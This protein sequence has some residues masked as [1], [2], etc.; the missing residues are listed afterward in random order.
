M[1]S[2]GLGP[3]PRA[4]TASPQRHL[5]ALT[6][7]AVPFSAIVLSD[8]SWETTLKVLNCGFGFDF[9]F[10]V[11]MAS[12]SYMDSTQWIQ[13][14]LDLQN[15]SHLT[16]PSLQAPESHNSLLGSLYW[17]L[18][19]L[20]VFVCCLWKS[21][22]NAPFLKLLSSGQ[23]FL[24]ESEAFVWV[25]VFAPEQQGHGFTTVLLI[26]LPSG[27]NKFWDGAIS[28]SWVLKACMCTWLS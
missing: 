2:V 16:S 25:L 21:P 11:W 13:Q 14:G 18:C 4:C 15:A 1:C 5:P 9:F 8:G 12:P 28:S 27:Q 6:I 23:S 26:S 10:W 24:N 7:P 3:G 22:A 17:K 20:S 19:T